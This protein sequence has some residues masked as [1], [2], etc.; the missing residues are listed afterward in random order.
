MLIAPV[1]WLF[2]R[3]SVWSDP[4]DCFYRQIW[5]DGTL[6]NGSVAQEGRYLRYAEPYVYIADNQFP[7]AHFWKK[8][9]VKVAPSHVQNAL[10]QNY[11][12]VSSVPLSV[13]V[14]HNL[15]GQ[16]KHQFL[17]YSHDILPA[18]SMNKIVLHVYRHLW[19]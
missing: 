14:S 18:A 7:S 6:E 9:G 1:V 11:N 13:P 15:H 17:Q 12:F 5:T 10:T 4:V 8:V 16:H 2:E 3:V 19:L